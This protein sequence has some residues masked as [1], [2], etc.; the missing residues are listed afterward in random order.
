MIL[1]VIALSIAIE[2]YIDGAGS[3]SRGNLPMVIIFVENSQGLILAHG[4]GPN[5][6]GGVCNR[7]FP[8][9]DRWNLTAVNS[10]IEYGC[11]L[12]CLNCGLLDIRPADGCCVVKW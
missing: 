11:N 2:Y 1:K 9:D 6:G 8:M 12:V 4:R 5:P 10:H 3:L 7:R